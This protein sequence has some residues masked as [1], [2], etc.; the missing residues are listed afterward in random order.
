MGVPPMSPVPGRVIPVSRSMTF[1]IPQFGQPVKFSKLGIE[2]KAHAKM[3]D[4]QN[5]RGTC[6][7][8]N[9]LGGCRVIWHNQSTKEHS[10]HPDFIERAHE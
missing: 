9:D 6:V 8:H 2:K 4:P 7:G 10:Y 3:K 1:E 5:A